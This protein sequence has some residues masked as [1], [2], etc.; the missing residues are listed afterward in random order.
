MASKEINLSHVKLIIYSEELAKSDISGHINSLISNVAIRPRTSIAVCK[1]SAK[2][3]INNVSPVLETSPARYYVLAFSAYEYSAESAQTEILDFYT[4]AQSEYKDSVATIARLKDSP[5]DAEKNSTESSASDKKA[6]EGGDE[7]AKSSGG[8]GA[9]ACSSD[10]GKEAEFIGL[11]AFSGGKMVGE[12]TPEETLAHLIATNSL[13]MGSI[14]I[15]DALDK[16]KH[17]SI[18]IKQK[19][20][21]KIDVKIKD[22]IPYITF[23]ASIAG[24]FE[25]SNSTTSYLQKENAEI[26]KK[27]LEDEIK[28]RLEQYFLKTK[29]FNAD[30]AGIGQYAKKNYL[31][32]EEFE[33]QNWKEIYKNA[34]FE[35]NVKA[36]LNISKITYHTIKNK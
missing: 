7:Q 15:P 19:N 5:G 30:I 33:K 20:K 1:G 24:H 26:L 13:K 36:D 10:S 8:G 29:E 12:I 28:K 14:T 6:E 18:K 2:D 9:S 17:T 27:S 31:T 4:S 22:N 32:F 25:S 16:E 34:V 21:N 3:F 23:E 11:A 35:V